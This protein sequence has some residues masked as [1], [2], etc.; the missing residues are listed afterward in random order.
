MEK[1]PL[2][3]VLMS[4]YNSESTIREAIDSILNQTYRNFEFIIMITFTDSE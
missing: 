4:C 3:S 1:N 2:V